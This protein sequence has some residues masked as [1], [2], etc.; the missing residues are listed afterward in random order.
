MKK[1]FLL[2]ISMLLLTGCGKVSKDKLVDDFTK[3]VENANSYKLNG[4]LEIYNNEDVFNYDISVMY[5]KDNLFKVDMINTN[6]DNEQIILRD[7]EAVYVVTPSLNKS[8]KFVSEW[9]FNS[10]QSYILNSLIKDIKEDNEIEYLTID[11]YYVLQVDVN[12]P[13]NSYL[14][15]EKIMFDKNMNLK[16]VIVYD[17]E[18]IESI[19]VEF[20]NIS[21]DEK[22]DD[23]EFNI[24][25]ILDDKCCSVVEENTA[26]M[27]D[28]I[29]PLYVPGETYLQSKDV[30][31]TDN[32]ER[33]ILTFSGER[34]FVL[35]EEASNV[36][37]EFE[38]IPVY[39]DLLIMN[40]TIG[41]LSNN[42]L[43]W[44]INNRDYYLAS[45]DLSPEEVKSIAE[46]LNTTVYLE[47]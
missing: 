9:P 26:N 22:V 41:A 38:T 10:S 4:S 21:Y 18:D 44:S 28:I 31:N 2:F 33:V 30:V 3:K 37:S 20:N 7:K 45:N 14:K 23:N 25:S 15:Y 40:D 39:G 1:I 16:K 36:Y 32:G 27:S 35:I 24:D 46:S 34:N 17:S 11:D 6:N 42:S 19:K 29:Y 8:Y 13:N 12:Y 5:K 47:K 43:S